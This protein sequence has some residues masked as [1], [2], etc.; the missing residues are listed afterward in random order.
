M[1]SAHHPEQEEQLYP[2]SVLVPLDK[3]PEPIASTIEFSRLIGWA[4]RKHSTVIQASTALSPWLITIII[5]K[6][7]L[8]RELLL[9]SN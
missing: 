1:G 7:L 6:H 8:K 9:R 4:A 5:L 2:M 3:Q